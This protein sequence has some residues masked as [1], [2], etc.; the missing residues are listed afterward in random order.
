M[1]IEVTAFA[2]EARWIPDDRRWFTRH[3]RRSHRLRRA[4]PGE[5][6]AAARNAERTVVRQFAPGAR[7][8]FPIAVP[9]FAHAG[10]APDAAAWAIFDLTVEA[11]STGNRSTTINAIL[12]RWELLKREG[13]T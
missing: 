1:E 11:M 7:L 9:W 4:H 13:R 5:W 10:A 6:P 12:E 8:R 3:P 2:D